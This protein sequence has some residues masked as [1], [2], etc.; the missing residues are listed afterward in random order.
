MLWLAYPSLRAYLL[1][2]SK[3][4]S[5]STWDFRS[6]K[7]EKLPRNNMQ[8]QVSPTGMCVCVSFD[9]SSNLK[10]ESFI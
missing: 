9:H 2:S 5:S 6:C 1:T 7:R 4:S 3:L 8:L 10:H